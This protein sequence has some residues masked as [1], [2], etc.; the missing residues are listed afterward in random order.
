MWREQESAITSSHTV[1]DLLQLSHTLVGLSRWKLY[2]V[3]VSANNNGGA[4]PSAWLPIS[5]DII[6]KRLSQPEDL[7]VQ[8]GRD[9]LILVSWQ[10][11]N[12]YPEC[13]VG[14]H[15]IYQWEGV[16]GKQ[17]RQIIVY[18][19]S[20][21]MEELEPA[22]YTFEV[23]SEIQS[24]D[25][26]YT[27][28]LAASTTYPQTG[29]N[30]GVVIRWPPIVAVLAIVIVVSFGL[31]ICLWKRKKLKRFLGLHNLFHLDEDNKIIRFA[32]NYT[33]PGTPVKR[34]EPELFDAIVTSKHPCPNA[35]ENGSCSNTN[36]SC[37][38][39]TFVN[40]D[41]DKLFKRLLVR[42][43]LSVESNSSELPVLTPD[44]GWSCFHFPDFTKKSHN[45]KEGGNPL[46]ENQPL[47]KRNNYLKVGTGEP[48][49][50][51]LSL[52]MNDLYLRSHKPETD[53]DSESSQ[54]LSA[55]DEISNQDKV[56]INPYCQMSQIPHLRNIKYS[57]LNSYSDT[58]VSCDVNVSN[59]GNTFD[60]K[61]NTLPLGYENGPTATQNTQD[62]YDTSPGTA[63]TPGMIPKPCRVKRQDS[64]PYSKLAFG[65][66]SVPVKNIFNDT[67]E[68]IGCDKN[69]NCPA[70]RANDN[71]VAGF[72]LSDVALSQEKAA[73]SI[74]KSD[75]YVC[76]SNEILNLNCGNVTIPQ[77]QQDQ[78]AISPYVQ[79]GSQ[80]TSPPPAS[81]ECNKVDEIEP[82]ILISEL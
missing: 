47:V 80:P 39:T 28:G 70:D 8:E 30:G 50:V 10:P 72:M 43:D 57:R 60:N 31:W 62:A 53:M 35:D 9:S 64:Y 33:S 3:S 36:C 26:N 63:D 54:L 76:D 75:N 18:N 7:Q 52:S 19:T 32:Q 71:T 44:I 82:Y 77:Q 49:Q 42:R 68:Y 16:D 38:S 81:T 74:N 41:E 69:K 14:Y 24:G 17:R 67:P 34:V 79:H 21:H 40:T 2:Q 4:T 6:D 22:I 78:V 37:C 23:A 25:H 61:D 55:K 15:V 5:A 20:Y 58:D 11:P 13:I 56:N 48:N 73:N 65:E 59:F 29:D 1:T 51:Q 66:N 12:D 45:E 27:I 46:L